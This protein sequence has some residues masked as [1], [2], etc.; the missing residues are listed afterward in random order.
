MLW[1][2]FLHAVLTCAGLVAARGAEVRFTV[3]DFDNGKPLPCRIHIKDAAG[4]AVRPGGL[5]F[6]YDHFVCA[7]DEGRKE[8]P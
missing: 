2:N 1:R 4:K 6:W 7:G 3:V 8:Y 5:P